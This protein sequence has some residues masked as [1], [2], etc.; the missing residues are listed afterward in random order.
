MH[1][2]TLSPEDEIFINMSVIEKGRK[3]VTR[4]FTLLFPAQVF[5]IFFAYMRNL[6]VFVTNPR[7]ENVSC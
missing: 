7:T 1:P 6:A 2:L 3:M 4:A 5:A